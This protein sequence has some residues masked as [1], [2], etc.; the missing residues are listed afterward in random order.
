MRIPAQIISIL[1]HPLL[2]IIYLLMVLITLNPYLFVLNDLQEKTTFFVYT[3][4]NTLIIPII[5]IFI[6]KFLGMIKSLEMETNKERIGPLIVIGSLYLW[7]VI[8]FKGNQIVPDIFS[9][10]V[11]G[12]VI[13]I[14]V[15][16]F[17]N[18]FTKISLHMVGMGGM[19]IALVLLKFQMEQGAILFNVF[20]WFGVMLSI[21]LLIFLGILVAG[22]TGTARLYL[23]AHNSAQ[24]YQGFLIGSLAQLL[25]F[26]IIF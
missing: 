9:S 4:V 1:F 8:N 6:M 20:D 15:A 3:F 10:I 12:S 7:M 2:I 22:I 19:V 17:F 13:G 21:D 23:K 25:A 26:S 14:F 5:S 16:F 11:L 18:S 24:V